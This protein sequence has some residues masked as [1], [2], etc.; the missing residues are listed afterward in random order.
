MDCRKSLKC[1]G[2]VILN[3]D[4]TCIAWPNDIIHCPSQPAFKEMH[5]RPM[6]GLLC[7]YLM[8]YIQ[9]SKKSILDDAFGGDIQ[10]NI[11]SYKVR[12]H[13]RLMAIFHWPALDY[14]I[15]E[16]FHRKLNTVCCCYCLESS[17]CKFIKL[18]LTMT[19]NSTTP[20]PASTLQ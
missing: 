7:I 19:L 14:L 2:S 1:T 3:N 5:S 13:S 10:S 4:K 15:L 18:F 9:I 16:R 17:G 12:I 6:I 11:V 20:C 8:C